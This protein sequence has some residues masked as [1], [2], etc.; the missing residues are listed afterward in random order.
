MA[1]YRIL[2]GGSV[3]FDPKEVE[4]LTSAYENACAA[5]DLVNRTDPLTEIIAKMI[6]ERAKAGELDPVRLM[7][8]RAGRAAPQP[9]MRCGWA[10]R[11]SQRCLFQSRLHACEGGVEPSPNWPPRKCRLRSG[12][13]QSLLRHG[14]PS[15]IV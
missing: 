1:I 9:L 11:L 14:Y 12:R 2:S 8:E 5:L 7:R 13:T 4:A 10:A 15:E 3:V 6:I